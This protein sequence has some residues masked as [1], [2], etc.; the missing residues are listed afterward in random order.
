MDKVDIFVGVITLG[1][2]VAVVIAVTTG[3]IQ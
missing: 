2:A 3:V 1:F